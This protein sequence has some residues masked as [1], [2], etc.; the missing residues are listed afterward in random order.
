MKY[1][2]REIRK[3]GCEIHG[4]CY[5]AESPSSFQLQVARPGLLGRP[6]IHY[7]GSRRVRP[8]R[9]GGP[10]F[11]TPRARRRV[12]DAPSG[13]LMVRRDEG[14]QG[15]G[16]EGR[17]GLASAFWVDGASSEPFLHAAFAESRNSPISMSSEPGCLCR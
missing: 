15:L 8:S 11:S 4:P 5:K 3:V 2:A 12:A 9:G 16:R 7:G 17:G 1:L 10:Y 13:A 14:M 6:D